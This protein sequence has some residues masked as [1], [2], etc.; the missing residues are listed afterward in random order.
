MTEEELI[1]LE[2]YLKLGIDDEDAE[3]IDYSDIPKFLGMSKEGF[4]NWIK[5]ART[6][7]ISQWVK[8]QNET[9]KQKNQEEESSKNKF[10]DAVES[11]EDLWRR[12]YSH[13]RHLL[14][15]DPFLLRDMD[16]NEQV[17]A[18]KKIT[19]PSVTSF[20]EGDILKQHGDRWKTLYGLK[21]KAI[22]KYK[23]EGGDKRWEE[24][25]KE[26]WG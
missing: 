1:R 15:F 5:N 8:D 24:W 7:N 26:T 2:Q 13:E 10:T 3:G 25:E 11:R 9:R 19:R 14:K 22:A 4:G 12:Y 16:V 6:E 20:W 21:D 18:L 17:E 23:R